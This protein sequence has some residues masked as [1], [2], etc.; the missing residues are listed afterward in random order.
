MIIIFLVPS[1]LVERT[2]DRTASSSITVPKFLIVSTSAAARPQHLPDAGEPG[3]RTSDDR[4]L[5]TDGAQRLR[6]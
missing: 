4:D 1:N 2:N 5:G 3:I 6:S